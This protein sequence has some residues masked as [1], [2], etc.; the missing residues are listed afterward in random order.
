MLSYAIPSYFI[1]CYAMLCLAILFYSTLYYSILFY[2]ILFYKF[3]NGLVNCKLPDSVTRCSSPSLTRSHHL[4]YQRPQSNILTHCY[5]FFPRTLRVW[6][7]LPC[8]VV[9]SPSLDSFRHTALP[10]IRSLKVPSHLRR[11]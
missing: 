7:S 6:N 4:A 10:A 11:L 8:E 1:I 2:F 5:S 3:H 9:T